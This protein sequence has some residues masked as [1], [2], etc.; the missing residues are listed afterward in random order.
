VDG[1]LNTDKGVWALPYGLSDDAL[2]YGIRKTIG[3]T[4]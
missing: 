1:H 2:G 4:G 3:V